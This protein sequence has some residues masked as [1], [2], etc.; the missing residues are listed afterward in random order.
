MSRD[1]YRYE[2][3]P[4]RIYILKIDSKTSIELR[5]HEIMK[6]LGLDSYFE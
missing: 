2:I 6:L 1:K 5:G 4:D 3:Y